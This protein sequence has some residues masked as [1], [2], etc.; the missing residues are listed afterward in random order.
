[1]TGNIFSNKWFF[2]F[3]TGW[4]VFLLLVDRKAFSKNIWGG[5][6]SCILELW[7]DALAYTM[8]MYYFLEKGIDI[9]NV[10]AFFTFGITFT[11]GVLFVQFLPEKPWLQII[12]LM[13]FSVG[14]VAFEAL[15]KYAGILVTPHWNLTASFFNN[16]LIFAGIMWFNDFIKKRA[17]QHG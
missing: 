5:V 17:G 14:F 3:V 8:G 4:G 2:T 13:A 11:M 1:M 12:H 16:I 15:V 7:E 6:L 10:S 9:L